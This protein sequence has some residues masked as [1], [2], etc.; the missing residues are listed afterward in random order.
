MTPYDGENINAYSNNERNNDEVSPNP[1]TNDIK[2]NANSYYY[3]NDY[4]VT[5]DT[6]KNG[7]KIETIENDDEKRMKNKPGRK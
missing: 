1:P 5:P 4:E 7:G 3:I 2:L 6:P